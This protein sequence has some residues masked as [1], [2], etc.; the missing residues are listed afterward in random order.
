[1]PQ[2][3]HQRAAELH[4]Q[5][6]HAHQAA[7]VHHGKEDHMTGH[8]HSRQARWNTLQRHMRRLKEAFQ[9]SAKAKRES[10]L[11]TALSGLLFLIV[12]PRQSFL[13]M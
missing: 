4:F 13:R 9:E 8:E 5:A 6:A 11:R 10:K 2:N 12:P 7:A 3:S 1:M